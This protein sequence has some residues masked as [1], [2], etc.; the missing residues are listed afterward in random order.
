MFAQLFADSTA[1]GLLLESNLPLQELHQ[2]AARD[3]PRY[4][5]VHQTLASPGLRFVRRAHERSRARPR[6]ALPTTTTRPRPRLTP[7]RVDDVW[8]ET[9]P[10]VSGYVEASGLQN[11]WRPAR[12]PTLREAPSPRRTRMLVTIGWRPKAEA[13]R[14][15]AV[16]RTFVRR[17]TETETATGHTL[18][19]L[20]TTRFVRRLLAATGA[21]GVVRRLAA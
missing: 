3:L 9:L 1:R 4:E 18:A 5:A 8:R 7:V 10:R 19:A 21:T 11:A 6:R 20:R 13:T 2:L 17:G 12:F 14:T 16:C 15:P